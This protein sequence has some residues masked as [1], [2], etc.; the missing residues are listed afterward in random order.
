MLTLK[1]AA[2]GS[3]AFGSLALFG[4]ALF[5]TMLS[6]PGQ[7]GQ[8]GASFAAVS[9]YADAATLR[10]ESA[11]SDVSASVP[12]GVKSF[13]HE[14]ALFLRRNGTTA[15]LQFE[16]MKNSITARLSLSAWTGHSSPNWIQSGAQLAQA[17]G[18]QAHSLARKVP[19]VT[20]A[21]DATRERVSAVTQ[22]V[23]NSNLG[24]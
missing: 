21:M 11:M 9:G 23:T 24:F 17:G 12:D 20:S 13:P 22:S 1:K 6:V 14:A 7:Q 3:F 18:G 5:Q 10:V 4:A 8:S 19:V 2:F 16:G 15:R